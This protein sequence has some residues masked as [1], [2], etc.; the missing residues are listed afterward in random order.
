[1]KNAKL[2]GVIAAV[3]GALLM[4][5]GANAMA[6]STDDIVNALIAKG[7]LTEEEGSLLM[8]G[9]A[10]EK[11]AAEKKAKG[12][13]TTSLKN[14]I[15]WESGDK[16]NSIKLIGRLH[17]DYRNFDYSESSSGTGGSDGADTFDI[18]RARVGFEGTFSEY[19]KFK[20]QSD[21]AASN[22]LDEAYINIGW[23]KPVQFRFG[24]FKMPMSLEEMTSSNNIDF[25]ERSLMNAMLPGKEAGAMVHGEPIKGMTYA[26]AL[27]SGEGQ[28]KTE[29][30][31]RVDDVDLIGRVTANFAEMMGN[32]DMVLHAGAS[33]S[34][35]D[36]IQL[37]NSS[38]IGVDGRTEGRG[39]KFFTAKA[40]NINPNS[41][42]K[43]ERTR[44]GVEGAVAYGPFKLQS[45]WF[46]TNYDF[47]KGA[48]N[49]GIDNDLDIDAWY[50]QA[51]WMIT[52]EKFADFY[53]GGE[54]KSVKP[55]NDFNPN[56]SGWGAWSVGVRYSKFDADEGFADI[57][58]V[59]YLE[60]D[61]YTLGLTF[62]ANPN[63][64]FLLN[65]VQTDFENKDSNIL[66]N[67]KS[68]DSE[69]A[70][71]LRAQWFF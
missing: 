56:G 70:L 13:V 1:M 39:V 19:Y 50:V 44:M 26:L 15:K 22:K 40:L 17:A 11:E 14:G 5:F 60:A 41:D 8:K 25:Q 6:D 68:E 71:T 2:R 46:Q 35:T 55:K 69:K 42:G 36:S 28:N 3:S 16:K 61:A 7:V 4:G 29:A 59:G 43:I 34:N 62:W 33:Y 65:Y 52:G 57:G 64:R 21:M 58:S 63:T 45:E 32:K 51:N 18:R 27:S 12:E 30:D 38:K 48:L 10:G 24:Q 66:V 53:K 20:V 37:D 31:I 49:T 9:R 23:W 67:G 54:W 47:T